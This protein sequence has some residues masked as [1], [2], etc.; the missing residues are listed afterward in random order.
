LCF[1]HSTTANTSTSLNFTTQQQ[2]YQQQT[3]ATK[4]QE[5]KENQING[6]LKILKNTYNY[7][8]RTINSTRLDGS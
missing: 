5:K 8:L 7:F 6:N 3:F 2:K 4:I 1:T